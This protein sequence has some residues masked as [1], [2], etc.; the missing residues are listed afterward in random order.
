MRIKSIVALLILLLA[1]CSCS[2]AQVKGKHNVGQFEKIAVSSGID[3]YFTQGKTCSVEIKATH[4]ED[5]DKVEVKV[6]NRALSLSK[7]KGANFNKRARVSAYV[8][9]PNLSDIAISGGSD[10]HASSIENKRINIA[11][12]GGADLDIT[13]LKSSDCN[14]AVSGGAD[15][16]I[17]QLEAE[18]VKLAVSGGADADIKLNNAGKVMVAASGGADVDLE[19][20]A[21]ELIVAS[22]GAADVD[23]KKLDCNKVITNKK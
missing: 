3:V 22:S 5:I 17:K 9:A 10:F 8:S 11:V 23:Y 19:G 7:K 1:F 6:E 20:K 21:R 14:I 15:C 2:S 13:R 18:A 12:S 16:D 4:S